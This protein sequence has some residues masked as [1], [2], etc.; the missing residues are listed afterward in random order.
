MVCAYDN[1]SIV[2]DWCSFHCPALDSFWFQRAG[3]PCEVSAYYL[4][5]KVDQNCHTIMP[6]DQASFDSLVI[7]SSTSKEYPHCIREI[8]TVANLMI[9]WVRD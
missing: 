1:T 4:N 2:I 8:Y 7:R 6:F 5:R 9:F 3:L